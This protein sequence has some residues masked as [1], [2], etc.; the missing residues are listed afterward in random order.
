[1]ISI[2][3]IAKLKVCCNYVSTIG[4]FDNSNNHSEVSQSKLI[5]SCVQKHLEILKIINETISIFKFV[6][7]AQ[8]MTTLILLVVVSIQ[9]N[10]AINDGVMVIVGV[11]LACLFQFF[12]YCFFGQQISTMVSLRCFKRLIG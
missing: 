7:L 12:A 2:H 3:I 6:N 10:V 5:H 11:F 1:M 9:F 4:D 8:V